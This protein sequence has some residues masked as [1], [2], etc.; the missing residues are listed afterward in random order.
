MAQHALDFPTGFQCVVVSNRSGKL[1]GVGVRVG[2]DLVEQLQ[3]MF[4]DIDIIPADFT[5][6]LLDTF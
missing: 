3:P 1:H 2:L 4:Q 6:Q 5:L